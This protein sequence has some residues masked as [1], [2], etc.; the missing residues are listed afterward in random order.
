VSGAPGT[1]EE[2]NDSV[3]A[4]VLFIE[5]SPAVEYIFLITAKALW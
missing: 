1:I 4:N 3:I 2:F 5:T